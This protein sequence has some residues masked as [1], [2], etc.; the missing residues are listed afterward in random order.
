[1]S[2]I[3]LNLFIASHFLNLNK[4]LFP[5]PPKRSIL[6]GNKYLSHWFQKTYSEDM[7][8]QHCWQSLFSQDLSINHSGKS[9]CSWWYTSSPLWETLDWLLSSAV[10][11]T[12]TFPRTYSLENWP[13]WMPGYPPQW[14]PRWWSTS[15]PRTKRSLSLKARY[16]IFPFAVSVTTEH[17][18]LATMAYDH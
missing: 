11:L 5:F 12:F 3:F 2:F 15:V 13:L 18:L 6:N 9:P 17:F 10:T 14:L 7:E 16:V 1:M 4:N 8:E